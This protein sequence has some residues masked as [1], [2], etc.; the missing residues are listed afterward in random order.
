LDFPGPDG[1]PLVVLQHLDEA[2]INHLV[3]LFRFSI[4]LHYTPWCWRES[5]VIFI[6]KQGK[7][8]YNNPKSFRPITLSSFFLKTLE[9]VVL[10]EIEDRYLIQNPL[11]DVQ[12]AFRT[13]K[14]T[15]SALSVVV[16]KIESGMDNQHTIGV[17]LD[18]QG[19]FDN[20][21]FE[22]AISALVKKGIDVNIIKWYESYI[23][24]RLTIYGRVT[25]QLTRGTPQGGVLSPLCWNLPFDEILKEIDVPPLTVVGFADDVA[26][27]ATGPDPTTLIELIQPAINRL[28]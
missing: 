4:S 10:W 6:P 11:S 17:F 5:K 15:D 9:R 12:H 28:V 18:I 16:D 7:D 14:S 21:S 19:A 13:G 22:S 20:I 2:S 25:K 1:F 8:N 23:T 3:T 27:L 24:K 26:I